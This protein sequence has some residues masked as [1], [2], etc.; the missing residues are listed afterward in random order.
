VS[1]IIA[2]PL[3]FPLNGMVGIASV[4]NHVTTPLHDHWHYRHKTSRQI[5]MPGPSVLA[6]LRSSEPNWI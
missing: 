3:H 2:H 6:A 1:I 4:Q 5:G